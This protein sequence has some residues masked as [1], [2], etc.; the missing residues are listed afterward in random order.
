MARDQ[1]AGV[2]VSARHIEHR[3]VAGDLGTVLEIANGAPSLVASG[4]AEGAGDAVWQVMLLRDA[5]KALALDGDETTARS[6]LD[7]ARQLAV[8]YGLLD[9]VN[10]LVVLSH[11][12]GDI[13]V[14]HQGNDSAFSAG[15]EQTV[16]Y[17]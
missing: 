6:I 17:D 5:A 12:I 9:Q 7:Q 10:K 13:D 15:T 16:A 14:V 11:E 8:E 3:I 4:Q 2:L 1:P